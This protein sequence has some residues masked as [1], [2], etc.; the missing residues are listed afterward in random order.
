MSY[1]P[2]F[3]YDLFF[4]YASDDNAEQWVEKFQ[5]RLTGELTRLLGRPFS[6]R[7]IYFD[8]LRL[9]VG[10]AYPL[11]LDEAARDSA[12][13]VPLISPSY[14]SSD[15]CSRERTEFAKRLPTG[16]T[17]AE[18]LAASRVRPTGA[19]PENLASAQNV[20]FVIPGFEAPWPADSPKWTEAVDR[21]AAGM[22]VALQKLRS[23]AGSVFTG[24]PLKTNFDLRANIV[25]YLS[26]Q[27]FRAAP[28]PPALL[29]DPE[30]C[31]KALAASACAVH[32][33]GGASDAALE[34]IEDSLKYCPGP[35][36]L[37]QPFGAKLS[38]MEEEFLAE[39]DPERY[40]HRIGPNEVELKRFLEDLLTRKRAAAAGTA[41]SLSLVCEPSDFGWAQT[42]NVDGLSVAYPRF[43]QEKLTTME[44]IRKWRQIVKDS[45]GL[46]F[47]QGQ[48]QEPV[49][50]RIWRMAD[51]EQSKAVRRWY[52]AD[53]GFDEKRQKRPVDPRY[54]E[55]L[56]DFIAE[57]RRRA[58]GGQ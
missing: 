25:D 17:F 56:Q 4:S 30:A 14:V 5:A 38:A 55:G 34:Q 47:Y 27:H 44:R 58:E 9:G 28:D 12:M 54:D 41:P 16:A 51:D 33:V 2:G 20:N 48:S 8:K 53:P 13:L 11:E 45:H 6:D 24:S 42:F 26:E 15:W 29:D 31:Q 18:C 46:L 50:D 36:V 21:L 37:F 7:T 10:Q 52:L 43:L 35:T 39:L 40:P 19:L 1:V 32:F 57:V 49:L 22:K 3:R 23:R